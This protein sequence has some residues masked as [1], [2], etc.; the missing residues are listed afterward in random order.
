MV[1][2]T[3]VDAV[4]RGVGSSSRALVEPRPAASDV[5]F[6]LVVTALIGLGYFIETVEPSA[7][8]VIAGV[9]IVVG[10]LWQ[11]RR[12]LALVADLARSRA[13]VKQA[14]SRFFQTFEQAAFGLVHVGRDGRM[15]RV[16]RRLCDITGFSRE[17]L[18]ARRLFDLTHPDDGS[19]TRAQFNKA[20]ADDD[21]ACSAEQRYLAKHGGIVPVVV[22]IKLVRGEG[23]EPDYCV[24][25]IEDITELKVSAHAL[26]ESEER[27][28]LAMM[29]ANDGLWDLRYDEHLAVREA[30]FSPRYKAMLGYEDGEIENLPGEIGRLATP[31][32]R[33]AVKAQVLELGSRAK[34]HYEIEI[35][36]RHKDGR[37]LDIL[38]RGYPIYDEK[39]KMARLVGTCV[40]ITERKRLVT[41]SRLAAAVFSSTHEGI[42]VTDR[43]AAIIMVNPAFSAITGYESEDVAGR[44]IRILQSGQHGRDFYQAMWR[45]IREAG[46]WQGEIWNRRKSG[47]V[48]PQWL[49]IS[50]VR[51]EKGAVTNYAGV[52]NDISKAKQS[53]THLEFL[54][55][56]DALTGLPNRLLLRLRIEHAIKRAK[57]K[58]S[59]GAVLFIDLDR[60][61]TVN[62]SL[63]HPAGDKLLILVAE[64][65]QA[66]MRASDTLAREGGDEFIAC[67]ED[68]QNA[69]EVEEFSRRL[70]DQMAQPFALPGAHEVFVGL[71]IGACLFPQDGGS[72]DELV[73][74]AD[75]ALYRAKKSGGGSFQLY[76]SVLTRAANERLQL[77][78][79]LRRGLERGEFVLQYQPLVSL[80][81]QRIMGVEALVRWR[82]PGGLI[83]PMKFIPL[84]EETGLIVPLGA[85]VLR[86][87]CGRLKAW[88]DAGRDIDMIAVNLSARQFDRADLCEHVSAILAETGLPAGRLELEITESALMQHGAGAE[89]KLH[90]LKA[91]GV[92]LAID[93]FGTGHSSL[94]YLK[95]FPIDKLKIDRS[96]IAEIPGDSIGMEI[97]AT[98]IRLAHSL[99]VKALAEGVETQA[100]ADFLAL[101]GCD[102]AQG[103]LFDRPLWEEELIARLE[104]SQ[105]AGQRRLA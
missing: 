60:F 88:R 84:A 4:A 68:V 26:R 48:Y 35:S 5:A 58:A 57:R 46:C 50:A 7:L 38:S 8:R 36:L 24:G 43:D 41:E 30:Y 42:V 47:E 100:Q 53:E 61:K 13:D 71:S 104:E 93:D 6:A 78:S 95:R 69:R 83:Q 82:S 77:E 90:V 2:F 65:L 105:G 59:S 18:L 19:G 34:D 1:S 29:G 56:H 51:D 72:A 79:G 85:W 52:F 49:T 37:W 64:R 3:G 70:I 44:H 32:S 45:S 75:S 89:E 94:A 73:Q 102:V 101:C 23:D 91:L 31:E 14:E 80:R 92:R 74:H 17:E 20:M 25:V 40:D 55:H 12:F 76:S 103:Y 63:G 11:R 99:K 66:C 62:D 28:R 54:A 98:V 81:D 9:V 15:L 21:R 96:F 97:T 67:I 10:S 33:E 39:G 22:S 86:E 87:A 16:N 27:F